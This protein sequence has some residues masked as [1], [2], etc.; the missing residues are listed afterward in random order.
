MH[1]VLNHKKSSFYGDVAAT[2]LV[3]L[4]SQVAKAGKAATASLG[5]QHLTLNS[6]LVGLTALITLWFLP[7]SSTT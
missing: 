1:H 3:D 6:L 2:I 5:S 7:S 4:G